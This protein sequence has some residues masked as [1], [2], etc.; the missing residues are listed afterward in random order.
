MFNS[1]QQITTEA[2]PLGGITTYTYDNLGNK[3]SQTVES[4][5]STS[6][7][8]PNVTTNYTYNADNNVTK[9]VVDSGGGS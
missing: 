8:D 4:T 5:S 1:S 9:T 6:S 2:N 3:L 7:S